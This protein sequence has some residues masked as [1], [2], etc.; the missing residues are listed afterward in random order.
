M[1]TNYVVERPGNADILTELGKTQG[2]FPLKIFEPRKNKQAVTAM[3]FLTPSIRQFL[4]VGAVIKML[5][6]VSGLAP[7]YKLTVKTV[8]SGKLELFFSRKAIDKTGPLVLTNSFSP[9]EAI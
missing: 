5:T 3:V 1:G 9:Q 7:G 2:S 8:M 4:A 6:L